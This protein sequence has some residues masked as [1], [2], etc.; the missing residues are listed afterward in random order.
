[1]LRYTNVS[2]L[3]VLRTAYRV[4][5]FQIEGPDWLS[6]ERFDITA[7]FPEGATQEQVP[8]ML[9]SLLVERFGL[10]VHND[11]KEHAIYAL[12]VGKNGPTLK[13]AENAPT[14]NNASA[15]SS[16]GPAPVPP[17]PGG[18]P[19]TAD[20]TAM[21]NRPGAMMMMMGPN[22]MHMK[23]P[24]ITLTGLADA[25]SRFAERPIVNQTGIEGRYDFELDF[26]PE[27]TA[28][29]RKM[30][31]MPPPPNAPTGEAH[32][33]DPGGEPAATI[34]EAVQRYGLKLEPRKAAM[35]VLVIDHI[36]KNPTEN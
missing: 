25:L 27:K 9:Q 11:T 19:R 31:G 10:T 22:G 5:E 16:G 20:V 29:M 4:K 33:A 14:D 35:P 21:A 3:E 26:M 17:T 12:V 36:E 24:A 28:G 30:G 32:G 23:T 34:Y 18:G 15:A 7:K 6:S 1:M 13:P 8:E 2:L